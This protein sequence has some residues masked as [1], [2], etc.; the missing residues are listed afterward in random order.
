LDTAT[1]VCGKVANIQNVTGS[2]GNDILVGNGGNVLTGGTGRNLLIAGKSA[3]TLVGNSG[4]DVLVGGTTNYDTSVASLDA[5]MA[6]WTRTDLPYA[7]RVQ[8]LLTGGGLNGSTL[9]NVANGGR[10]PA[11]A[12]R[13]LSSCR[14]ANVYYN[15]A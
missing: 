14:N 4:K 3:S 1:G 15:V 6:E 10:Q 8:D 9:L 7:A 2:K 12:H 11:K 5:L 13:P